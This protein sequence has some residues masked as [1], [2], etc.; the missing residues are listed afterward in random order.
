M[1]VVLEPVPLLDNTRWRGMARFMEHQVALR[2]DG[3]IWAWPLEPL[4]ARD[5]TGKPFTPRLV[6]IGP[7]SD[8]AAVS[9]DYQSLAVR[10]TDGSIW[11]WTL[12][13]WES[14]AHPFRGP[15]VRLGSRNDW[16]A[17]GCLWGGVISLG[18]DGSLYYW[19]SRDIDSYGGSLDQLMLAPSRKPALIENIFARQ[20]DRS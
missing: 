9:G 20:D 1:G 19:S 10:K 14:R 16:V 17:I 11:Q 13:G 18:P 3:T 2:E 7:D 12:P 6:Q 15:P 8:W 5:Q 4:P